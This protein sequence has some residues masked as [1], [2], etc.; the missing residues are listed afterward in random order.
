M[1]DEK[2]HDRNNFNDRISPKM[3][4]GPKTGCEEVK[5]ESKKVLNALKYSRTEG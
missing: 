2:P 1:K 5:S 4:E 3:P